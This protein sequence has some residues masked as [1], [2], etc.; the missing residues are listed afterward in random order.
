VPASVASVFVGAVNGAVYALDPG[1]G[2][3]R[4]RYA[5]GGTGLP[6]LASADGTL[7]V[8]AGNARPPADAQVVALDAASGTVRWRVP[9]AAASNVAGAPRPLVVAGTVYVADLQGGLEALRAS[10][11]ALL[12]SDASVET[13]AAYVAG[14]AV[15]NGTVFAGTES[16][17]VV[18]VEAA[19][20]AVRWHAAVAGGVGDVVVSGTGVYVAATGEHVGSLDSI[21]ALGAATGALCWQAP[22]PP[23]SVTGVRVV[24]GE[25]LGA[26][27]G[28]DPGPPG[29]GPSGGAVALDAATGALRWT[30]PTQGIAAVSDAT[31]ASG[32][33]ILGGGRQVYALDVATGR[34]KWAFPAQPVPNFAYTPA[35][36][37][38]GTVFVGGSDGMLYALDAGVGSEQW[39]AAVAGSPLSALVL[40]G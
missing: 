10:D 14:L 31:V 8:G 16:G 1:T 20:G 18:A 40:A 23:Q 30:F 17:E 24:D 22:A 21:V 29:P 6:S 25:V 3:T 13:P 7:F 35:S 2:A 33:A 12:W 34:A 36:L 27:F 28:G 39:H 19:T 11:G 15:A 32:E 5:G 9:L 37:A 4:W 38:G 26:Y